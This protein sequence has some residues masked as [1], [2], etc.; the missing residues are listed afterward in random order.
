MPRKWRGICGESGCCLEKDHKGVCSFVAIEE[1]DYEVEAIV[2]QRRT[3]K[4]TEYLVKWLNWPT[5]DNTWEFEANLAGAG[6]V[7]AAWKRSHLNP[8]ARNAPTATAQSAAVA[9]VIGAPSTDGAA[10][11]ADTSVAPPVDPA[12]TPIVSDGDDDAAPPIIA[13]TPTAAPAPPTA[14]PAPSWSQPPAPQQPPPPCSLPTP[15]PASASQPEPAPQPLLAPIPA[16]PRPL[17]APPPPPPLLPT[18]VAKAAGIVR[19]P[20]MPPATVTRDVR[21]EGYKALLVQLEQQQQQQQ[22][23]QAIQRE[24]KRGLASDGATDDDAMSEILSE[25]THEPSDA[26]SDA[27]SELGASEVASVAGTS[28]SSLASPY[29]G[30]SAPPALEPALEAPTKMRRTVRWAADVV[31][32]V[33]YASLP[34]TTFEGSEPRLTRLASPAACSLPVSSTGAVAPAEYERA[35]HHPEEQEQ[36]GAFQGVLGVW[37]PTEPPAAGAAAGTAAGAA[38]PAHAHAADMAGPAAGDPTAK[39]R[40]TMLSS[41]M[42]SSALMPSIGFA[43]HGR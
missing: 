38:V 13:V 4:G 30:F 43:T 9:A 15:R 27:A 37:K 2:A 35:A 33:R 40:K 20:Q 18:L 8:C 31:N 36:H 12:A 22:Q 1:H 6:E 5:E 23:Q 28:D 11:D 10:H 32:E 39:R 19:R 25:S 42:M 24:A 7:L 21:L 14:S 41:A 16:P 29:V 17:P 26:T 3:R 34:H